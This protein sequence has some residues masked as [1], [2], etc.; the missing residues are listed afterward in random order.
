MRMPVV[1]RCGLL[2]CLIASHSGRAD[3]ETSPNVRDPWH[4]FAKGSWIVLAETR[5]RGDETIEKREKHLRTDDFG[6]ERRLSDIA[7][8]VFVERD[9]KFPMLPTRTNRHVPGVRAEEFSEAT[10]VETREE[11]VRI[12]DVEFKCVVRRY[13]VPEG[14]QPKLD[15]TIWTAEGVDVPY[16]E[17]A[18]PGSDLAMGSDVLK[19]EFSFFLGDDRSQTIT[20]AVVSFKDARK[21]G[22]QTLNCVR[23]EGTIKEVDAGRESGGSIVRWL[24]NEVPGREVEFQIEGR[25]GE[26]KL[27]DARRIV[28]FHIPKSE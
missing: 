24:S 7:V 4:G 12:E 3:D 16:R 28:E 11:S 21:I 6:E 1:T 17:L 8:S 27:R 13:H 10:L 25:R 22:E 9:G 23:E 5:S 26:M 14:R 2:I 18:A 20:L 15:I 19:A